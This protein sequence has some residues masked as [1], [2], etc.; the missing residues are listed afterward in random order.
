MQGDR[1]EQY[2]SHSLNR[3]KERFALQHR[4]AGMIKGSELYTLRGI[5]DKGVWA[6]MTRLAHSHER[7]PTT[8]PNIEYH[9]KWVFSSYTL[10]P[11]FYQCYNSGT[12]YS[13]EKRTNLRLGQW[14]NVTSTKCSY[15]QGSGPML[16]VYIM[17]LHKGDNLPLLWYLGNWRNQVFCEIFYTHTHTLRLVS[18][19]GCPGIQHTLL[20][21]TL[22]RTSGGCHTA[23]RAALWS[24]T[25]PQSPVYPSF[26]QSIPKVP[27]IPSKHRLQDYKT[28]NIASQQRA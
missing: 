4:H 11:A 1:I 21:S 5:L 28:A 23:Q 17:W 24:G 2:G 10:Y 20:P 7:G 14:P 16:F 27:S 3:W 22:P 13:N 26:R 6:L 8:Q 19:W 12:M 9:S 18:P 15:W 25:A